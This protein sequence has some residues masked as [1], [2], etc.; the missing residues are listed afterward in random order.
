MTTTGTTSSFAIDGIGIEIDTAELAVL[1]ALE[2][3]FAAFP[4]PSPRPSAVRLSYRVGDPVAAADAFA[5]GPGRPVYET[6][7]GTLHHVA[8]TDTVHGIFGGVHVHCD[9]V[10]SSATLTAAAFAG[11]DLY[12][13]T[14]P[15]TTV[16]LMELLERAGRYSLH[17]A[18]LATDDGA[19]VLVA[20]PSGSGK[21][22]LTVA[23]AAAGMTFLSDD[24]VFLDRRDGAVD[25]VGFADALGISD[26]VA[27]RYPGLRP[28]LEE[29]PPSGFPKRLRRIES[30]LDVRTSARCT[31]RVLVLPEIVPSRPSI[32]TE[33]DPADAWLGLVP[34]VLLTNPAT[35]QAHLAAIAAL[36][37]QV[38]CYRLMS[39]PSLQDSAALVAALP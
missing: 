15:L 22:S 8:A 23:L 16:S 3:R 20:G 1:A 10:A 9:A 13:A 24:V 32:V 38:R 2:R 39:G 35:T 7:H 29:P 33:I 21:S 34:D 27:E 30:L 37:G 28:R 18:C 12:V 17:A 14:H 4:A 25:V 36:L 6:R 31:P 5:D 19:G 26:H 11:T